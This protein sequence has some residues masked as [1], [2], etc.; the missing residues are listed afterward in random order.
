MTAI[1]WSAVDFLGDQ[2]GTCEEGTFL[3]GAPDSGGRVRVHFK[4]NLAEGESEEGVVAR[5]KGMKVWSEE[6]NRL[7]ASHPHFNGSEIGYFHDR[8]CA[9]LHL[10]R[11][12]TSDVQSAAAADQLVAAGFV[13]VGKE[14][15]TY[16][17]KVGTSTFEVS[18]YDGGLDLRV[19]KSPGRWRVLAELC[20]AVEQRTPLK[21]VGVWPCERGT[22]QA[23]AAAAV[24]LTEWAISEGLMS[25]PR[26]PARTAA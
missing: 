22:M 14:G 8:D 13:V 6:S 24:A 18:L 15:T 1:T 4:P 11:M 9:K 5:L 17:R 25:A 19:F 2:T 7:A 21:S 20:L 23:F 16:H 12:L 26:R 3:I 10:E